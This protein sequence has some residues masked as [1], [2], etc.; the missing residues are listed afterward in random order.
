M[1]SLTTHIKP[2]TLENSTHIVVLGKVDRALY[3]KQIPVYYKARLLKELYVHELTTVSLTN[4][5]DTHLKNLSPAYFNKQVFW[6]SMERA[7]GGGLPGEY[8]VTFIALKDTPVSKGPGHTPWKEIKARSEK[9]FEGRRLHMKRKE[10]F[11]VDPV[12]QEELEVPAE[13]PIPS[14]DASEPRSQAGEVTS[15]VAMQIVEHDNV[16]CNVANCFVCAPG[17]SDGVNPLS[18]GETEE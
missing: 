16:S 1:N 9:N 12:E 8:E 7:Y 6:S 13:E 5:D 4:V 10:F 18:K 17:P 15:D 3:G 14:L 11:G 2:T